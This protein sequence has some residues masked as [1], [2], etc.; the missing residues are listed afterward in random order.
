[1]LYEKSYYNVKC[2]NKK[3]YVCTYVQFR[4]LDVRCA[5]VIDDSSA[6]KGAFRYSLRV[7]V[8][9]IIKDIRAAFGQ[10]LLALKIYSYV[11]CRFSALIA[12]TR[13]QS[14]F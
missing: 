1:V 9:L 5:S 8:Y 10:T 11:H 2:K 14:R 12:S 7:L 4:I 3:S 6:Y 13:T